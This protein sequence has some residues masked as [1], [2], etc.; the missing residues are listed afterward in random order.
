MGWRY[1]LTH[2]WLCPQMDDRGEAEATTTADAMDD[3]EEEE[4]EEEPPRPMVQ[5]AEFTDRLPE[6]PRPPPSAAADSPAAAADTSEPGPASQHD[7][8]VQSRLD[9]AAS[10]GAVLFCS[11]VAALY[12]LTL[13]KTASIFAQVLTGTACNTAGT[14]AAIVAA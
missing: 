14:A 9:A 10:T 4:E 5:M 1:H 8:Q 6:A 2:A 11:G 7:D 3:D 13:L 12:P